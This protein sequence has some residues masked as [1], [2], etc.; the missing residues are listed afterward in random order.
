M[1]KLLHGKYNFFN[2]KCE[3]LVAFTNPYYFNRIGKSQKIS[4]E[5]QINTCKAVHNLETPDM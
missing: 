4:L 1:C 3:F 2:H 5:N